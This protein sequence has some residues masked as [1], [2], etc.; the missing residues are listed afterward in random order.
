MVWALCIENMLNSLNNLKQR[1]YKWGVLCL[2]YCGGLIRSQRWS[3]S[4]SLDVWRWF[5]KLLKHDVLLFTTLSYNVLFNLILNL[6]RCILLY[7]V[8]VYLFIAVWELSVSPVLPKH[9]LPSTQLQKTET[10]EHLNV[11]TALGHHSGLW[12]PYH[13]NRD[14]QNKLLRNCS[15]LSS[16]GP[17]RQPDPTHQTSSFQTSAPPTTDINMSSA[18]ES[19]WLITNVHTLCGVWGLWCHLLGGQLKHTLGIS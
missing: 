15:V 7:H 1:L 5:S 18:R 3:L 12:P 19:H 14:Q 11:L 17:T 8:K 16:S 10:N 6:A 2:K 9:Q 13:Y 4:K